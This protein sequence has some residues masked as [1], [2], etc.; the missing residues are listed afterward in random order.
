MKAYTQTVGKYTLI[1]T[2]I[3]RDVVCFVKQGDKQVGVYSSLSDAMRHQM[4]WNSEFARKA[5]NEKTTRRTIDCR[6]EDIKSVKD[7]M[8]VL[9]KKMA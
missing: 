3:G 9:R 1:E 6:G 5:I 7:M 4:E 8:M 2:V